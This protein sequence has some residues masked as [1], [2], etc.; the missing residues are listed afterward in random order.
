MQFRAPNGMEELEQG[1]DKVIS[2]LRRV[3]G[4]NSDKL[5]QYEAA[6]MRVAIYTITLIFQ[7]L[8]TS[9]FINKPPPLTGF[10]R[11]QAIKFNTLHYR[12]DKKSKSKCKRLTKSWEACKSSYHK[13]LYKTFIELRWEWE[14]D[15]FDTVRSKGLW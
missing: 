12:D 2:C 10:M 9:H 11:K 15:L 1:N 4:P 3:L 7:I 5:A 14:F 8:C 6:N 13:S